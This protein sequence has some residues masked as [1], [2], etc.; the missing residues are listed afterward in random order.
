MGHGSRGSWVTFCDP[1]SALAATITAVI[2]MNFN[3]TVND[4]GA[5]D[6]EG[7]RQ[8]QRRVL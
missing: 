5:C 8:L 6:R 7:N 4:N 1:L 3:H 2:K